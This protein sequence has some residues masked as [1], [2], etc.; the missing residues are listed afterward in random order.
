MRP[1]FVRSDS[2][3]AAALGLAR[4]LAEAD[5]VAAH[6]GAPALTLRRPWSPGDLG[7]SVRV[8]STP[9]AWLGLLVVAEVVALELWAVKA[10]YGLRVIADTPTYMEILRNF[11]LHPLA[12]E[13]SHY[14]HSGQVNVSHATPDMQVLAL[15]WHWLARAGH[16]SANLIDLIPSY[17][18]LAVKGLLVTLLLFH[19]LHLWARRQ[20]GG[21]A[22]SA[23]LA[24]AVLPAVFGPALIVSPGDLSF[25]GFMATADHSE[26]LAI[27]LLLYTLTALDGRLT[28][29]RLVVATLGVASV[30]VTHPFTGVRLMGIAAAVSAYGAFRRD[31]KWLLAPI[32]FVLGFVLASRWPAY[33]LAQAMKVGS[34]DGRVIVVVLAAAPLLARGASAF[35]RSGGGRLSRIG[36]WLESDR[37]TLALAVL[38][39]VGCCLVIARE[40]WLYTHPDPFLTLNRR[41][42]YWNGISLPY[43]PLLFAPAA[44]GIGGLVRLARR[45][46][47]AP[48]LWGLGCLGIGVV[49]ALGLPFPLW[50]RF[51][52]FAQIP[53]AVGT[54]VVLR[55]AGRLLTS[56]LVT[57]TL[58]GS[59]AFALATLVF[60][61]PNV[62]YFGT[63]LQAGWRLQEFVPV[64]T[65]TVVASDP[66]T[67]YFVLPLGDRVL[68]M[69]T[70]HI[71]D[72]SEL[73]PARGGYAL[74][75]RLYTGRGWRGAAQRMWK[76][77]VR[78]V[79]VNRGFR[80]NAPTLDAF[81]SFN[82]PYI[83]RNWNQQA[84]VVAYM[85]RLGTIA[86]RVGSDD[87][88]HVYRLD[89][90]RVFGLPSTV[91]TG[92]TPTG[93]S[94]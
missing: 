79:V 20:C 24:V 69:T 75:H 60:M 59:A 94:A 37:V 80:M 35:R 47:V 70:W 15:V 9:A 27:A 11:A 28:P 82:A 22:R 72:R 90:Q 57:A 16:V 40:F 45:G 13:P 17:Q 38:G 7:T 3:H 49:G 65:G 77:G 39:I 88:L 19:A 74:M 14:V 44:A 51:L 81:S 41:S 25:N 43:W 26:S 10:R 30:L 31:D 68:T 29:K 8:L 53:L 63:R 89:R 12:R 76:L 18:L 23:W 56:R 55:E 71:N 46:T 4:K 93:G 33:D 48:L 61:P 67:E 78:Y 83:V 5:A 6:D 84:E 86:N 21:D 42:I 34:V 54:A 36:A 32:A 91:A 52:L 64:G 66:A 62:T 58:V 73:P 1:V 50:H 92:S 85:R 87:E 2:A